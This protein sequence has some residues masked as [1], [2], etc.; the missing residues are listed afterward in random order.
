MDLGLEKIATVFENFSCYCAVG[1]GSFIHM[2]L[3]DGFNNLSVA[4]VVCAYPL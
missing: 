1:T 4:D 3:L 2:E